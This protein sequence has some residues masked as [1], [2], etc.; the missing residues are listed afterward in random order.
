M[1]T[2]GVLST[3]QTH[4]EGVSNPTAQAVVRGEPV[5]INA[6]PTFSFW[7][8]SHSQDFETLGDRSTRLTVTIRCYWRLEQAQQVKEAL[9]LEIYN[10]IVSIKSALSADALL[11]GNCQYSICGT[12][13][14]GY[15]E[16]S[17]V[18]FKIVTMP[19]EID[20]YGEETITP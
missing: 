3:I 9:E 17:G 7:L 14:T 4:L 12:A 6:S 5:M 10:A 8:Q 20:V 2:S 18:T 16:Q 1:S 13:D 19:F 11:G 15:L